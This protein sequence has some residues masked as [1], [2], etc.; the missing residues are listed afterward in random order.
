MQRSI[1]R[2][3]LIDADDT[4]WENNIF[5][6]QCTARFQDHMHGLG[7][8]REAVQL[9]LDTCERETVRLHGYGPVGYIAA[10]GLTYQRLLSERGMVAQESATALVRAYGEMLLAPPSVLLPGVQTTLVSLRPSTRLVLVTKGDQET[11]QAKLDRSG[12]GPLLDAVYIVT[13]KNADTYR[14]IVTELDLD[15]EDTWMVGNSPR[16]D[17]NPAVEAGLGAIL[18]PHNHTWTAEH[19]TIANPELV[20]T[21]RCF[22][23]L[24]C[25]FGV[26]A[27]P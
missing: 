21:L 24:L 19:E 27:L 6:L 3:L 12:L 4:L 7:F 15:T 20:I 14:R 5:Y 23:E 18:V 8:E 25:Y 13:E 9:A 26:E 2:T 17:I 11:Q 1:E 16:S 10:L 22:S